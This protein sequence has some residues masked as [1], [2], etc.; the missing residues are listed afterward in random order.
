MM[1]L[2]MVFFLFFWA[3]LKRTSLGREK[4]RRR[5]KGQQTHN[6]GERNHMP[7]GHSRNLP[8]L[9]KCYDHLT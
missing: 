7:I 5:L 1:M 4:N 3:Q 6:Q 2:Q 8:I 9:G